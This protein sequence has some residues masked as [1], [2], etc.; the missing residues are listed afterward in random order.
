MW[1]NFASFGQNEG[2]SMKRIALTLILALLFVPAFAAPVNLDDAKK[3][4]AEYVESGQY[5][6]RVARVYHRAKLYLSNRI[7]QYKTNHQAK[8]L[9][10]VLDID[11]TLLSNY[12]HMK[13][14]NF[15][16]SA[17]LIDHYIDR[18]DDPAIPSAL[19]F[20][21]YAEENKISIFFVT[22]RSE[23]YRESTVRNLRHVGVPKWEHL[24]MRPADYHKMSIIDFKAGTRAQI[25][26][27]GYEVVESIGDQWSDIR[28]GHVKKGYKLPNPFYFIP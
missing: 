25:E 7:K 3:K 26:Q 13:E 11:E 27:Q 14:N 10:V 22:G 15:G 28:G 20:T 2:M 21:K 23:Q 19:Q 8:K 5:S 24:Y 17:E 18:G 16:G 12:Q 4:A 9:A 6:H 1:Y